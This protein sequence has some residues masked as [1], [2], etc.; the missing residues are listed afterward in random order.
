MNALNKYRRDAVTDAHQIRFRKLGGTEDFPLSDYA[1]RVVLVVNVASVCGLTPQYR[2]LEQ[3]YEN[4]K[5]EGLVVL[6]APCN[7][8]G[9]QEPGEE[10]EIA[11]F[12][13]Q[14]YKVGFPMTG[15]L[16]I[17]ARERRHPFYRWIV[18][19]VGE[20]ALPRWNFHKYLIGKDGRLLESFS[21][22]TSPLAPEVTAA[23]DRALA[24]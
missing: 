10:S 19:Q 7:E 20:E 5:D 22:Q 23:I 12:C 3:L 4:K 11:A 6:G 21:S 9:A 1:G 15:K 16:D 14:R 18:N 8:F 17:I 2:E 24:A 13:E